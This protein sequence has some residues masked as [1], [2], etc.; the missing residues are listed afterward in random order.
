MSK[1][2][3]LTCNPSHPAAT[4]ATTTKKAAAKIRSKLAMFHLATENESFK[5]LLPLA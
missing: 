3:A 1:L 2:D 5:V 4:S